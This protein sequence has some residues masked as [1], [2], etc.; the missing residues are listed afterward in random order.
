MKE[1]GN[2]TTSLKLQI[3][4]NKNAIEMLQDSIANHYDRIKEL[5]DENKNLEKEISKGERE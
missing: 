1:K 5:E 2:L 4:A 3:N